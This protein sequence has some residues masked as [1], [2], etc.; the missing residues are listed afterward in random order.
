VQV[1][2]KFP[3]PLGLER[4]SVSAGTT[5]KQYKALEVIEDM[6]RYTE[7]VTKHQHERMQEQQRRA[8]Y[9]G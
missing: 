7:L 1:D 5:I 2:Y 3:V 4:S 6:E 9:A 8:F